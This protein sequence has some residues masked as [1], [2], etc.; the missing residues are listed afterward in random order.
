MR[1]FFTIFIGVL[2]IVTATNKSLLQNNYSK[3]GL[4]FQNRMIHLAKFFFD[5]RD[6]NKAEII[7]KQVLNLEAPQLI[8]EKAS[9]MLIEIEFEKE[10]YKKA[11]EGYL[12]YIRQAPFGEFTYKAYRRIKQINQKIALRAIN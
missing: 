7:Y 6:F 4:I 8:K 1:Y 10:K 3:I 9:F 5:S 11:Q 12:N 2:V